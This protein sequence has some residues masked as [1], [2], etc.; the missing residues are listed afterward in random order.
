[1]ED[2][3]L[4]CNCPL[5]SEWYE[6][7]NNIREYF[8]SLGG[9]AYK[10]LQT[11]GL[12]ELDFFCVFDENYCRD[13][14]QIEKNRSYN[15]II[16]LEVYIDFCND[17][18]LEKAYLFYS[19]TNDYYSIY[20]E[21][22]IRKGKLVLTRENLD[23]W[24]KKGYGCIL[25][26]ETE[27][28][29]CVYEEYINMF[30]GNVSCR[31][32]K[33]WK[34]NHVIASRGYKEV[35]LVLDYLTFG[36][37]CFEVD[38]YAIDTYF[39]VLKQEICIRKQK[40]PCFRIENVNR[41]DIEVLKILEQE[42]EDVFL[43]E[44]GYDLNKFPESYRDLAYLTAYLKYYY[45]D[46]KDIVSLE[47]Y[48]RSESKSLGIAFSLNKL[49]GANLLD[50]GV[51]ELVRNQKIYGSVTS[52]IYGMELEDRTI[53][54]GKFSLK[55]AGVALSEIG[56]A[57]RSVLNS[58]TYENI[59]QV[60]VCLP[61]E[62]PKKE[63]ICEYMH[64]IQMEKEEESENP[65][66][67]QIFDELDLENVEAVDIIHMALQMAGLKNAVIVPR[68]IAIIS[69]Y[70]TGNINNKLLEGQYGVVYDWSNDFFFVSLV[71]KKKEACNILWQ[72]V[73]ENPLVCKDVYVA[74]GKTLIECV[75][76]KMHDI[77]YAQ[78]EMLKYMNLTEDNKEA[79]DV[80]YAS[81]EMVVK[82]LQND[83]PG[84]ILLENAWASIEE[85][86]KQDEFDSIFELYYL[87]TEK[88]MKHILSR[89]E[90]TEKDIS[91]VY[92]S[93]EWGN[94]SGLLRKLERFFGRNKLCVMADSKY[95]PVIGAAYLAKNTKEMI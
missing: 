34:Q 91:K 81:A 89:L 72:E 23:K 11:S 65:L 39:D 58:C 16:A 73:I 92:I 12:R 7:F 28:N 95:A 83:R 77:L 94:Y 25:C 64:R 56:L 5:S 79:W 90:I 71:Q 53:F 52:C 29:I 78:E 87:K 40:N 20:Q 66:D 18:Q 14:D 21:G 61:A 10:I 24:A 51:V 26:R 67:V 88:I 75:K 54:P 36:D 6:N 2:K 9:L 3:T 48:D 93:G 37:F 30:Q 84:N 59:E 57:T 70:E 46:I 13:E 15:R 33:P 55:N 35:F 1:M 60:V 22:V 4:P 47:E 41:M 32:I 17:K 43:R 74:Q 19:H 86:F 31:N 45:P 69:A 27:P 8:I 62:L 85:L 80:L 82:Q 50:N 38:F 42:Q 68:A 63:E 44:M 76:S 49:M